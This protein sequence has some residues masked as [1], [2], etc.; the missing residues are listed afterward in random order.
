[1]QHPKILT[2]MAAFIAQA[3]LVMETR[4]ADGRVNSALSEK[5]VIK[6]LKEKFPT[7]EEPMRERHWWDFCVTDESGAWFPVNVKITETI[8]ADNLSS[9]EGLFYA[10]TGIDPVVSRISINSW[11]SFFKNL[12][13]SLIEDATKDYYFLVV[14]KRPDSLEK[15]LSW[16]ASLKTLNTLTP[17]GNNLPFQCR[18]ADNKIPHERSESES[19]FFLLSHLSKSIKLRANILDEFIAEFPD[20]A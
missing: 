20:F 3:D 12:K 18:W 6:K 8:T 9:K 4:S 7:V 1:M 14:D 15:P 16:I 2:D 19:R 10:L 17:N 5:L 11:G 13:K